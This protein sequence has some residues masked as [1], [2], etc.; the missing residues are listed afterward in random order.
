MVLYFRSVS[1]YNVNLSRYIR[2]NKKVS[3]KKFKK[4]VCKFINKIKVKGNG[5]VIE[6]A[7]EDKSNF[8]FNIVGNNNKIIVRKMANIDFDIVKIRLYGDNNEIFIDEGLAV[9]SNF[10]ILIGQDHPKFG[11]VKNSKIN[12]GKNV[13]IESAEYVTFNSNTFCNI[14]DNCML[15]AGI[16]LYNTDAHPVFDKDSGEVINKV[17]GITIGEHS[18]I[19][20]GASVLKNSYVPNDSI[21]G[22]KSVYSGNR[23]TKPFCAYAGNPAKC[24]KE[25]VTWDTDGAKAGY[26]ENITE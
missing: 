6:I 2:R 25:N 10:D 17:R 9:S 19:G 11:K 20:L 12:I 15:S 8:K 7:P 18:W 1:A 26:I 23:N 22:W 3:S 13:S 14:G 5:N 24:I 16:T 21:I 4:F